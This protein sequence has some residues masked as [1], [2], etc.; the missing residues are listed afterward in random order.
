MTFPL[1][2]LRSEGAAPAKASDRS[3]A[4]PAAGVRVS[5]RLHRVPV[6]PV[7]EPSTP[8]ENTLR[9]Q[10]GL[11][12]GG[13]FLLLALLAMLSH[14]RQDPAFTTSGQHLEPSNW[15][16][17]LGAYGSDLMQFLFGQSAWWLLLVG[18]RVLL[19]GLARWL[20]R[21]SAVSVTVGANPAPIEQG[22]TQAASSA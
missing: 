19:G 2:S 6:A 22:N 16:G 12:L 11:L 5:G 18:L 13:V 15:V 20:R 9:F 8:V 14:N 3:R 10:A 1:G 17:H 7:V 4:E 21:D